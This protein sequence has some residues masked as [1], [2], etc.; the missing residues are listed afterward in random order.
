MGS[1][2]GDC[3]VAMVEGGG[4]VGWLAGMGLAEEKGKG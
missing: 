3:M 1:D 4:V 2:G